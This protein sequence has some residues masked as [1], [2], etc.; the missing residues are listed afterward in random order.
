MSRLTP[1]PNP[2]CPPSRSP[3]RSPSR[4]PPFEPRSLQ[5]PPPAAASGRERPPRDPLDRRLPPDLRGREGF[6]LLIR[7]LRFRISV[8]GT[9]STFALTRATHAALRGR[10]LRAVAKVATPVALARP[11]T[12]LQRELRRRA[13]DEGLVAEVKKAYPTEA[14]VAASGDSGRPLRNFNR[15][16]QAT[17]VL[18]PGVARDPVD[19][20][21]RPE[22]A[23]GR[24]AAVGRSVPEGAV[25]VTG[26]RDPAL[27]K[28]MRQ[29]AEAVGASFL[30]AAPRDPR[31]MPGLEVPTV[32]DALLR[33]TL[34]T[35]L[36]A[37]ERVQAMAR[38]QRRLR[39]QPSALPGLRVFDATGLPNAPSL[40]AALDH[41]GHVGPARTHA[42][43]HV[44]AD[45]LRESAWLG[46]VLRQALEDGALAHV[47]LVGAGATLL[48]EDLRHLPSTLLLDRR[49]TV[50][51]VVRTLARE[52][53][54]AAVVT[55][56]DTVDPWPRFLANRLWRPEARPDAWVPAGE[57]S[58]DAVDLEP[59]DPAPLLRVPSMG[60]RPVVNVLGDLDRELARPPDTP[61]PSRPAPAPQP[62]AV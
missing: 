40:R 39:W 9:S 60:R 47:C 62:V 46:P 59:I 28:A 44:R 45:R 17:H 32:L 16:V 53:P 3:S 54:G 50:D 10:R 43:V 52:G 49:A 51:S 41:L 14:L 6:P 1:T 19:G 38:L 30:D 48:A 27:R 42:V 58:P 13:F 56:G 4:P 21:L 15:M 55:L 18:V 35:G 25:L 5:A 8:A 36:S 22:T 23:R 34:G 12:L 11:S 61:R 24:A 26:E 57:A 20:S 29:E 7:R 31:A 37:A 2:S 33:A